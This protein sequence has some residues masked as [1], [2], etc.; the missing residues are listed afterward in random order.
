[1]ENCHVSSCAPASVFVLRCSRVCSRDVSGPRR[2]GQCPG[3][4]PT[5]RFADGRP[6]SSKGSSRS[7]S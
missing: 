3:V 5:R 1:V 4:R 7:T 6:R 2:A